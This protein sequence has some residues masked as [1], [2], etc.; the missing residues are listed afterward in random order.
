M[1]S[2]VLCSDFIYIEIKNFQCYSGSSKNQA[3][4]YRQ[5][6]GYPRNTV[7]GIV[8][9]PPLEP[10]WQLALAAREPKWRNAPCFMEL[11]C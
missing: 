6:T 3:K 2:S 11:L 4:Y 7:S 10:V 9:G 1:G 5:S 8:L